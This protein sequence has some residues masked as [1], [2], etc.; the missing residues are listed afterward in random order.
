MRKVKVR[1]PRGMKQNG[2]RSY[3]MCPY[4]YMPGCDP[5]GASAL[6]RRKIEQRLKRGLCPACGHAPCRCKSKLTLKAP[7]WR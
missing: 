5:F 3:D 7:I 1:K 2:C 6:Y 4:C